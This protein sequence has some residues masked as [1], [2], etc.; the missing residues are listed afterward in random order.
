MQ[1]TEMR[2]SGM[3]MRLLSI[4]LF[5]ALLFGC[6]NRSPTREIESHPMAERTVE[7]QYRIPPEQSLLSYIR[8]VR[9]QMQEDYRHSVELY[10]RMSVTDENTKYREAMK[11]YIDSTVL[12][13]RAME[14][15]EEKIGRAHVWTPVTL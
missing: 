4:T 5:T 14:R 11:D 15:F 2:Y 1:K 10:N 13:L 3:T 7:R 9:L 12:K 6:E 8:E